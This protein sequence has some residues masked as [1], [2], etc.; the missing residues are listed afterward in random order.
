MASAGH[1]PEQEDFPHPTSPA[2]APRAALHPLTCLSPSL[3][4]LTR[5]RP[6]SHH[7]STQ[8]LGTLGF[9]GAPDLKRRPPSD[10]QISSA[11][12]GLEGRS[13]QCTSL[14]HTFSSSTSLLRALCFCLPLSRLS[15]T[16]TSP[17]RPRHPHTTPRS[18][19]ALAI[20]QLLSPSPGLLSTTFW[21]LTTGYAQ[22]SPHP[23]YGSTLGQAHLWS[24]SGGG[25]S[26]PHKWCPVRGRGVTYE[27]KCQSLGGACLGRA[28]WE[29]VG[30]CPSF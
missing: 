3:P 15:R 23:K 1:W 10:G 7:L 11:F 12:R 20:G 30:R 16:S 6:A 13:G 21:A 22:V 8:P 29:S 2:T 19:T 28:A 26:G 25:H 17:P 27:Y 5:C 9:G 14:L 18:P 24:P 4:P